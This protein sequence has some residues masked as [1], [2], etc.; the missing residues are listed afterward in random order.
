MLTR[1]VLLLLPVLACGA[2]IHGRTIDPQMLAQDVARCLRIASAV[3]GRRGT[4]SSECL[5]TRTPAR[6]ALTSLRG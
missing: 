3:K 4:S 1:G 5:A 2:R 6:I